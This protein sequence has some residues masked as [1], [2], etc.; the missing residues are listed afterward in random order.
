MEVP[1]PILRDGDME[2][3]LDVDYSH[4]YCES[5]LEKQFRNLLGVKSENIHYII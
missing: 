5:T 1:L 3:T 2:M 4:R